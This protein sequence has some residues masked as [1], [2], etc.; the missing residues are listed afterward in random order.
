MVESDREPTGAPPEVQPPTLPLRRDAQ[1]QT[2]QYGSAAEAAAGPL[3][4]S[5][6]APLPERIGRYK[7]AKLLGEGGFGQVYL[8][9]DEEL[10]R[11]VAVKVPYANRVFDAEQVAQYRTEARVVANLNDPSIVRI[12]DVGSTAA[13]P[14][15]LVLEY[16]E[17][18]DL[19]CRMQ[20]S[21]LSRSKAVKLVAIVADTLHHAHKH[22]LVHRD[23]KPGNIL[24][25]NQ[26]KPFLA[27]FGLALRD[28]DVGKGPT[29]VGTVAYMSPEQSV[30]E[31]HRVDGRS[32]IFSLG[33]ILYE[34]LVM[35]RP[36]RAETPDKLLLEI[37]TQEPRPPRQYDETI[38][39]ELE[40]I[41]L[42]A[43]AKRPS[44]RYSTAHD[45]AEE[46]RQFVDA[47]K[48]AAGRSASSS[49]KPLNSPSSDG[50]VEELPAAPTS[51]RPARQSSR[52]LLLLV[53]ATFTAICVLLSF[54]GIYRTSS[55]ESDWNLTLN[56]LRE[57][58]EVFQIQVRR[59]KPD[60]KLPMPDTGPLLK[61]FTTFQ[62]AQASADDAAT[63]P[64]R[65]E[66]LQPIKRTYLMGH[67]N[68]GNKVGAL[69]DDIDHLLPDSTQHLTADKKDQI[70]VNLE[71]IGNKL[72]ELDKLKDV[73]APH[74]R[75][76][77]SKLLETR[78][79]IA[80][81]LVL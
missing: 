74:T 36:F 22:G 69:L 1:E 67:A 20:Q 23:V 15:F 80:N 81:S 30:G 14:F 35:R 49:Q 38:P 79:K 18:S 65:K 68:L 59:F 3:P 16:I 76:R 32:D 78:Q 9:N 8:A 62:E 43:L 27:D 40:R 33:V 77:V 11:S 47:H 26:G 58:A 17:G 41:C 73:L 7:V 54:V 2:V 29:F 19:A 52:R 56:E 50:T 66:A 63:N 44:D 25:D 34:L 6:A 24:I 45:F 60:L 12:Y 10:G 51:I 61:A 55:R 5:A 57:D 4:V 64:S 75:L 13:H 53:A 28:D 31:G 37:K 46:L 42:K 21:R 39:K 72:T 48:R 70:K 71:M